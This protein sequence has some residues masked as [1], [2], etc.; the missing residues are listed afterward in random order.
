M[1]SGVLGQS[2]AAPLVSRIVSPRCCSLV[3][4]ALC[5]SIVSFFFNDCCVRLRLQLGEL[6][7]SALSRHVSQPLLVVTTETINMD[8]VVVSRFVLEVMERKKKTKDK[9]EQKNVR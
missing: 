5:Q 1:F 3:L 2:S 6:I 7:L 9:Q 4:L 8:Q